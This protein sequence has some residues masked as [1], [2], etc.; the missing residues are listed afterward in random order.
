ME[1]GGGRKMRGSGSGT[2]ARVES[3]DVFT[4]AKPGMG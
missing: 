1:D 4:L 3:G 2:M